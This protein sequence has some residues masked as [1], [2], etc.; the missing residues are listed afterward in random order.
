MKNKPPISIKNAFIDCLRI[1]A[2]TTDAQVMREVLAKQF[3][4]TDIGTAVC[5]LDLSKID[6]ETQAE[7]DLGAFLDAA[8]EHS[9][10]IVGIAGANAALSEEAQKMGL[11]DESSSGH[12]V[13][14]DEETLDEPKQNGTIVIDKPLRSGQRIY[15][16]DADIIV[17]SVVNNGAEV[18]ADG[19][20]HVYAPL[21]GRAIAG[22]SGNTNARIF[23]Q[24]MEPELISIAGIYITSES[25]ELSA[26]YGQ[27]AQISLQ[28]E[29]LIT[30]PISS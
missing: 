22:A 2:Q 23:A 19:N 3:E 18:I 1:V 20:I 10:N 24:R 4:N 30:Q 15:A 13:K 26:I 29:T 5:I 9:L 14:Q 28:G 11:S 7:I 12:V 25:Q 17:L 27:G 16:K 6:A 8:A 21:R